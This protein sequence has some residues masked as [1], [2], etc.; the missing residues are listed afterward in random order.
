MIG[1][2]NFKLCDLN[3][4]TMFNLTDPL[5]GHLAFNL[6]GTPLVL[7]CSWPH[8]SDYIFGNYYASSGTCYS[9]TSTVGPTYSPLSK[10][11][12]MNRRIMIFT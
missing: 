4:T 1:T 7:G 6:G 5:G 11:I 9:A 12:Y 8:E 10:T 3:T 2:A